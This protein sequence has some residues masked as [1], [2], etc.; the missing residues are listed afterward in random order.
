[1]K[2]F[3]FLFFVM[4]IN[5]FEYD[6]ECGSET[7]EFSHLTGYP[8]IKQENGDQGI[9]GVTISWGTDQLLFAPDC[10]D[11]FEAGYWRN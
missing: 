10:A 8:E 5:A 6:S 4:T 7:P 3:E 9:S 2:I 1:M 11:A